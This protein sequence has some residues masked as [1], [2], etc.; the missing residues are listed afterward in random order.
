MT[1]E[2]DQATQRTYVENGGMY[3][4]ECDSEEVNSTQ[5]RRQGDSI[6]ADLHCLACKAQWQD[7]F[8]LD[9][10]ERIQAGKRAD[11][12]QLFGHEAQQLHNAPRNNMT[13]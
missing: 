10:V 12:Q 11:Q 9:Q 4:P 1:E 13:R 8:I 3:C 2:Y 6:T 5:P 7:T